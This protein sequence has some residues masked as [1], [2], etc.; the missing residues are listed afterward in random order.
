M[1]AA[2]FIQAFAYLEKQPIYSCMGTDGH[3]SIKHQKANKLN[4]C[5]KKGICKIDWK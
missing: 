4:Y 5:A 2:F 3:W 1:G